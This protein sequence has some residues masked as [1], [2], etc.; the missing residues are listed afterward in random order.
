ALRSSYGARLPLVLMDSFSTRDDS[1][2]ALERYEELPADVPLDFVQ[3]KEPKIRVDDLEPVSWPQQPSLE[4]C[5]PGHGDLYTALVTSGLLDLLREND[6]RYAFVSNSDN[7]RAT[8]DARVAT[9]FVSSGAP[10]ATEVTRR[11]PAD[12]KGGHLAIRSA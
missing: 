4:W 10:F 1:L 6:Y 11:T 3:N 5:P 8:V 2:K 7:L 9:W 12:R